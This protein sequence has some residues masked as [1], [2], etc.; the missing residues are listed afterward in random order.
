MSAR[1]RTGAHSL[2]TIATKGKRKADAAAAPAAPSTAPPKKAKHKHKHEGGHK[3][4]KPR[5]S[6]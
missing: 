2:V 1:P 6:V 4:S 5:R 3:G